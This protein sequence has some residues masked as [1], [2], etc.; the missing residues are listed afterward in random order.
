MRFTQIA[1]L[2]AA[3][4]AKV[5][6]D[7]VQITEPEAPSEE[8]FKKPSYFRRIKDPNVKARYKNANDQCKGQLNAKRRYKCFVRHWNLYKPHRKNHL[9][10]LRARTRRACWKFKTNILKRAKC[11]ARYIKD[12]R[13]DLYKGLLAD[14][15]QEY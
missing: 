6:Y 5:D 9:T 4:A 7:Y 12:Y 10:D 8:E 3:V 14:A 2:I 15:E 1:A 11:F 13:G